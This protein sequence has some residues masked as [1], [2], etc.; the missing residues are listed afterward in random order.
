MS[1]DGNTRFADTHE[2][3]RKEGEEMVVGISDHAQQSL[4]DIVFVELPAPG[5][6]FDAKASFGVVESVKAASDVYMPIAGE[7][8]AI[9]DELSAKPEL[10]NQDCYGDGWIIKIKADN[11]ADFDALMDE[12]DYTT[13]L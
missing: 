6:H 13:S 12:N 5:A 4:G 3:A 9:N 11:P 10:V 8:V 1:V 2:W 7:V